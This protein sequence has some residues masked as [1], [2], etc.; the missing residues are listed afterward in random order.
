[1]DNNAI[2][3]V[4][5]SHTGA[6]QAIDLLRKGSFDVKKLSIVGKD[7]HTE[8]HVTGYYNTGER[9]ST[10]GKFGAFWGAI[11]GFLVG[12]A[13]FFIPGIGPVLVGGPLVVWIVGALEG[14]V[15]VGG[16]SAIGGALTGIG[17]PR[18]SVLMYEDEIRA[19]KF[20][21]VAHGTSQEVEKAKQILSTSG[22]TRSDVYDTNHDAIN[23]PV[24][25]TPSAA[26]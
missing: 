17:I 21:V 10:W 7:Y 20:V 12:S 15:L 5:D 19:E 2:V 14:A 23:A 22:A 1:M 25:A 9:M 13:F 18:D 24:S 6:E 11:W 8:E 4:Y 26:K 3:A 16:L